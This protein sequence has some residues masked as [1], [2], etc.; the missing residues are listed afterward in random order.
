MVMMVIK[1]DLYFTSIQRTKLVSE[2]GDQENICQKVFILQIHH[3]IMNFR[4]KIPQNPRIINA[5]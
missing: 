5:N 3:V 1:Y 4:L 2:I